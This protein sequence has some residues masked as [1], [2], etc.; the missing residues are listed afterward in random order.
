MVV[1]VRI[2]QVS[3]LWCRLVVGILTK[4]IRTTGLE[5]KI[6]MNG[7]FIPYL[8]CSMIKSICVTWI[9]KND[10]LGLIAHRVIASLLIDA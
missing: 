5:V 1:R 2:L 7:L 9:F 6:L 8:W 4:P 10:L 3:V